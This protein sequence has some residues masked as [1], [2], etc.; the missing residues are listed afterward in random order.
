MESN[1]E[2]VTAGV[3]MAALILFCFRLS[4]VFWK[5][6]RTFLALLLGIPSALYGGGLLIANF[7]FGSF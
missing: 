5:Q 7:G 6:D 4:F 1:T 2:F 3:L